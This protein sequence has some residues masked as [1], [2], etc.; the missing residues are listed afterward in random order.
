MRLYDVAKEYA[1]RYAKDGEHC[2]GAIYGMALA[3]IHTCEPS[4]Q[5][6][7]E[8]LWRSLRKARLLEEDAA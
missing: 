5:E 3:A 2:E 1:K 6:K 4:E 8:E 7:I